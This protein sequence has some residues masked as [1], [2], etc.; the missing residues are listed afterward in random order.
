MNQGWYAILVRTGSEPIAAQLLTYRGYDVFL[1]Q[2]RT[3]VRLSDRVKVRDSALFP[4]YLFCRVCTDVLGPILSTPSVISIVGF[5]RVPTPVDDWE[6]ES[7]RTALSRQECLP[8]PFVREGQAVEIRSGALAG[9]RGLILRIKGH[10]K[11]V[12]SIKLLQR[13]VAIE[14]GS[15]TVTPV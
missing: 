9:G 13:S 12:L 4:G 5:G 1:P 11:L 6:I 2:Y 7:L 14:V 15:E 3:R 10:Y 8:W